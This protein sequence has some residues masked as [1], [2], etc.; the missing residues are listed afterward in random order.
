[1]IRAAGGALAVSLW[2]IV[3]GTSAAFSQPHPAATQIRLVLPFRATG[4]LALGVSAHVTGTCFSG[5]LADS[6]RSDAWRCM[7][8]NQIYDPCF[9]G[10]IGAETVVAC[11]NSPTAAAAVVRTPAGGVP[12]R[13][14][15]KKDLLTSLPWSLELVNGASCGMLTGATAAFAGMRVNYGCTNRGSVIGEVDRSLLRWRVFYQAPNATTASLVDVVTAW[16]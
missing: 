7:S 5:S 15:S 13:E 10:F 6:G 2:A 9:A 16:Y 14:A 4:T 8:G 3:I 11:L 1:M 12:P